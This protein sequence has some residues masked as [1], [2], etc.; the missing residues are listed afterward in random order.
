MVDRLFE[1]LS[2]DPSERTSVDAVDSFIS[3]THSIFSRRK[4]VD[5]HVEYQTTKFQENIQ[6]TQYYVSPKDIESLLGDLVSMLNEDLMSKKVRGINDKI[7]L[8]L[9]KMDDSIIQVLLF[10]SL[11]LLF[12]IVSLL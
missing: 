12:V 1:R 3:L 5:R 6:D 7:N 9:K 8:Q 11:L 10:F 4:V 2:F